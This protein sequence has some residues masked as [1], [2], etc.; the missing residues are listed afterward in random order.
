MPA[1]LVLT[2][3]LNCIAW[4]R[5]QGG[6]GAQV[7]LL[8]HPHRQALGVSTQAALR[9]EKL[10]AINRAAGHR[11]LWRPIYCAELM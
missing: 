8:G 2:T 5:P 10:R 11:Q 6:Q 3:R 4:N 9:V 1:V 7:A